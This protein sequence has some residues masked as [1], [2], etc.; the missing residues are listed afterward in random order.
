MKCLTPNDLAGQNSNDQK[1]F[2]R[3]L[4]G[5]EPP[6]IWHSRYER[7]KA[8]TEREK[9]DLRRVYGEWRRRKRFD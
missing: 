2:R 7:W 6:L 1:S 8:C 4:R 3:A 5:A 9:A